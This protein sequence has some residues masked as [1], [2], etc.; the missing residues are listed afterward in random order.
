MALG[1]GFKR[2]LDCTSPAV[3]MATTL[4]GLRIMNSLKCII[5]YRKLASTRIRADIDRAY[6]VIFILISY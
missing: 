5:A 6:T 1:D 3:A 2:A 4:K